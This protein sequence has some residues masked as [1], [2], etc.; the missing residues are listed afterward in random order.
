MTTAT[1]KIGS[2]K[3]KR[4][5]WLDGKRLLNAGFLGGY[6]YV[7]DAAPGRIDMSLDMN[8][9]GRIRKVTGRPD[10]KPIIDILGRDVETA[11]PTGT[12]VLVS[13]DVGTIRVRPIV[14]ELAWERAA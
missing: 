9:P 12:H 7:C 1:I 13:F 11:F 3:G 6:V 5:I 4:R 8:A 2:N 10:G 14:I